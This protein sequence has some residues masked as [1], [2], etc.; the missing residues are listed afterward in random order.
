MLN[1][2]KKLDNTICIMLEECKELGKKAKSLEKKDKNEAVETYK[3]A[4]HCYENND[5][6]R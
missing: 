4:A 1:R 6:E 3:Q 2:V 5:K